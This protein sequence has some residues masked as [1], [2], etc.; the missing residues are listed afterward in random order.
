MILGALFLV[1]V[2]CALV[3]IGSSDS[4]LGPTSVLKPFT[5]PGQLSFHNLSNEL[6][7]LS[8]ISALP[9]LAAF[10]DYSGERLASLRRSL[11]NAIEDAAR[12]VTGAMKEIGKGPFAADRAGVQLQER[13]NG[14]L[15]PRYPVIMVPGIV[16]SGLE[17]WKSRECLSESYFRERVWGTTT[18]VRAILADPYCWMDH[19]ALDPETGLDPPGVKLRAA[20]GLHSADEFIVNFYI[21]SGVIRNLADVGYDENSLYMASY[22][23]RLGPQQLERRDFYFSS[24]RDTVEQYVRRHGNPVLLIGHSMGCNVVSY[25]LQWVESEHGGRGGDGWVNRHV[26]SV[27][28]VGAP[29]AGSPKASGGLLSGEFRDTANMGMLNTLIDAVVSKKERAAFMRTW[30]SM[31]HL[32]PKGGPAVWGDAAADGSGGG[33]A[34]DDF[35]QVCPERNR[36]FGAMI[37]MDG[38]PL[39]QDQVH[40]LLLDVDPTGAWSRRAREEWSFGVLHAAHPLVVQ[41]PHRLQVAEL[42]RYWTNPLESRLP[43]APNMTIHCM[44]GVGRPSE[45]QYYYRDAENNMPAEG[46][47]H[48]HDNNRVS[49]YSLDLDEDDADCLTKNGVQSG[50]GDGTIP[51]LSLSYLCMEGWNDPLFN[52]HGV[53]VVVN[54]YKDN[55]LPFLMNPRGGDAAADHVDM[56][57]NREFLEEVILLAT[58]HDEL[59]HEHIHSEASRICKNIHAR[60]KAL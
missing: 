25:F 16:S 28:H 55:A 34:P 8:N 13:F 38:V 22:D 24:L 48:T 11:T 39:D 12:S 20:T 19:V 7:S 54:E 9:H 43:N 29:L 23:W 18:M 50:D 5:L 52:P 33:G 57:G 44:Y 21:W 46:V 42:Q 10:S 35:L 36:T 47:P 4:Q 53:K 56:L 26:R 27:L 60:V 40:A 2:I 41:G 58:G 6:Y 15:K 49:R 45:R 59:V 3:I 37:Y 51:L 30:T 32:L 17:A 1:A 14:T 31:N